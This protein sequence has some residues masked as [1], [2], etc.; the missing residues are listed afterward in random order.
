MFIC[1]FV[2]FM[3]NV[4]VVMFGFGLL[5]VCVYVEWFVLLFDVLV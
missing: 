2:L 1:G 5:C 4:L 3:E